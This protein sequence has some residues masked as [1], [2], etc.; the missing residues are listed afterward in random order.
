[1]N[2]TKQ[3]REELEQE[4]KRVKKIPDDQ[5]TDEELAVKYCRSITKILGVG[6]HAAHC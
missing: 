3:E 1:M 4:R 2:E 5:L 6:A